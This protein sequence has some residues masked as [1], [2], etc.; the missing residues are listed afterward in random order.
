VRKIP[1]VAQ[2]SVR[3]DGEDLAIQ[4]EGCAR[5]LITVHAATAGALTVVGRAQHA[6]RATPATL[7]GLLKRRG[8]DLP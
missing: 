8:G 3:L 6:R 7:V 2:R 1:S 4:H 5:V